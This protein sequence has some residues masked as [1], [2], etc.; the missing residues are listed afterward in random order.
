[1]YQVD[2]QLGRRR[3]TRRQR[4][5]VANATQSRDQ[6]DSPESEDPKIVVNVTTK[7]SGTKRET[8]LK[9]EVRYTDDGDLEYYDPKTKQ[10]GMYLGAIGLSV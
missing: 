6:S 7:R 4:P 8:S 10:W 1:M 9:G 3:S 2:A 5:I